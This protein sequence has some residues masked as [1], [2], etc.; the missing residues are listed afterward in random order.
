ALAAKRANRCWAAIAMV[1]DGA[2]QMLGNNGVITIARYWK[3]WDSPTLI[4]LVLNNQDLNQVTW[5]QRVMAGDPKFEVSQNVPDFPFA[6]YATML[7]LKGIKVRSE[8]HT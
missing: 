3:E 4:I 5:E 2:M 6:E 7:G 8:E 1:G